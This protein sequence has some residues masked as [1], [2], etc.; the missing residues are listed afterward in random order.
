MTTGKGAAWWGLLGFSFLFISA[1]YRLWIPAR[2]LEPHTFS[3]VDWSIL[4]CGILFMGYVKGHCIFYRRFA[5]RFAARTYYLMKHS[6][7]LHQILA[8]FF[9]MSYFYTTRK[10]KIIT[11][12]LTLLIVALIV[13][14]HHTSQ[15]VRGI[16]DASVMVGLTWGLLAVWRKTLPV[17]LGK[18]PQ[19]SP[20]TPEER[21]GF[22]R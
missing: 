20:E 7:R 4:I 22:N 3:I 19:E 18:I 13:W 6:N 21:R 14:V 8:P 11:Y 9:C 10:R 5:P 1:L 15:P 16:I 2:Q 12:S 17:L